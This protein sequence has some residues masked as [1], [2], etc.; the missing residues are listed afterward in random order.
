[1]VQAAL[2]RWNRLDALVNNAGVTTFVGP[3]GWE[4][5]DAEAFTRIMGVN[6]IGS[7]Q[8]VRACAPHLKASHGAVVNVSST[9]GISGLGSSLPYVASKGALNAMTL[10]MARSLAPEVRVNAVCPGLIDTRW[11]ADGMGIEAYQK[12]KANFEK[13]A[14]L[15]RPSSAE[16]IAQAIIWLID[17]A[18]S[19]TGEL[20]RL[21][22]G[23]HLG[24]G[25]RP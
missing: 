21:D 20:L 25:A 17:G 5:L 23:M 13:S 12:I 19:A 11:F 6:V 16:D 9:A 4:T 10:N 14:P 15:A 24:G 7:F 18:R 8:M 3:D 2:A 22:S 1:M